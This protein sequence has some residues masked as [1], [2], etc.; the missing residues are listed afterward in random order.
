MNKGYPLELRKQVVDF[1]DENPQISLSKVGEKFGVT[2]ATVGLWYRQSGRK[3]I[4]SHKKKFTDEQLLEDLRLYPHDTLQ[5]RKVRL[6]TSTQI[7]SH[8]LRKLGLHGKASYRLDAEK[9]Q[10]EIWKKKHLAYIISKIQYAVDNPS[11][12]EE[13]PQTLENW[14]KVLLKEVQELNTVG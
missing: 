4:S 3:R 1:I 11:S 14:L 6:G 8:R 7:V 10:H 12:L 9:K 13:Y 2:D 5:I